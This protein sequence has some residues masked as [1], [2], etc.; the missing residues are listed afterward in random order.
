MPFARV[1]NSYGG[2]FT[3]RAASGRGG[4]SEGQSA[5]VCALA[6]LALKTRIKTQIPKPK[7]QRNPKGPNPNRGWFVVPALMRRLLVLLGFGRSLGFGIWG[8][9]FVIL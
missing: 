7:S 2:N 5:G 9:G 3:S 8:L 6:P 4:A 1:R